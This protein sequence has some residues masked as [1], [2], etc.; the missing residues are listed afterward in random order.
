MYAITYFHFTREKWQTTEIH[1]KFNFTQVF[2]PFTN[3]MF[4]NII[5]NQTSFRGTQQCGLWFCFQFF[6]NWIFDFG[7][8]AL[9]LWAS[10]STFE[11]I[12]SSSLQ[13]P[14]FRVYNNILEKQKKKNRVHGY[15]PNYKRNESGLK[16]PHKVLIKWHPRY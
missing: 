13:S 5:W 2:V 6:S 10:V 14:T 8:V 3:H 11:S 9:I 4:T 16:I 12:W 7:K 15:F 1:R